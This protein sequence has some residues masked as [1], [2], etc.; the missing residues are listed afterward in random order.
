MPGEGQV[1]LAGPDDVLP[2]VPS[3]ALGSLLVTSAFKG[4]GTWLQSATSMAVGAVA[5]TAWWCP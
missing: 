2:A 4:T 1:Q 3:D 5:F